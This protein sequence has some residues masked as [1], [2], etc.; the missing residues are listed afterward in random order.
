MIEHFAEYALGKGNRQPDGSLRRADRQ[1]DRVAVAH[2]WPLSYDRP[3]DRIT[4]GPIEVE[5]AVACEQAKLLVQ[6]IWLRFG[7][8]RTPRYGCPILGSETGVGA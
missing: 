3:T 6:A 5:V 8:L 7:S 4:L 1:T 2:D